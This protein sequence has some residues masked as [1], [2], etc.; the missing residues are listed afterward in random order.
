MDAGASGSEKNKFMIITKLQGGLGN[1]LFQYAIGKN[2]ALKNNTELKL[3]ISYY[4]IYHDRIYSLNNFNITENIATS[5]EIKYFSRFQKNHKKIIGKI[6][7]FLFADEK[8]YIKEKQ[9]NFD[10]DAANCQCPVY[11][12]GFWQTEKYFNNIEKILRK[13]FTLKSEPTEQTKDW[14]KKINGLNSVSIHIRRGDYVKDEKTNQC[15]GACG[16]SYY[17]E[18]IKIISQ[19]TANP[20]FFIFSDDIEWAKNNLNTE[21][22]TFFVSDSNIPDYEEI[23]IMS[24]C[25]HNIIANSSF[26]WWAAWLNNNDNKIVISP[27]KWFETKKMNTIDIVPETWIKI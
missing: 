4:N 16:L 6:Y 1:Q 14:I 19:K 2:L 25:Q 9:F 13:E 5:K 21:Y 24:Q 12:D 8:K 18:A 11:L 3:D 22:S 23:I 10:Q 7:N 20:T 15:H 26:S 27:E 17:N